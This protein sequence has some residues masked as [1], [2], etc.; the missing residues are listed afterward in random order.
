MK[1]KIILLTLLCL[2]LNTISAQTDMYAKNVN[3]PCVNKK[4]FLYI[5]VGMDSL[6]MNIL[7]EAGVEKILEEANMAFEPICISFDY[8]KID[9]MKDYSFL[10]IKDSVD[11]DL[12]TTRF[13]KERRLNVYFVENVFQPN[14]NSFSVF[15]GITLADKGVIIVPYTGK[16][17]I[18]EL[19]NTFGLHHTFSEGF[20]KET[21]DGKNCKTAGDL[22]CDTPADP[23]D[24]KEKYEK[25]LDLQR[26]NFVYLGKDPNKDY[27][28]T[29]IGNYMTHYFCAHCFFTTSQYKI[30]AETYLNSTFK[31][32]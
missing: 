29:E 5:H 30:M 12:L 20:G 7:S 11:V 1:N 21:V 16:G 26:C 8:C 22:L 28:K 10:N 32:W 2:F 13:Q 24:T 15:N 31:M 6:S 9:Y 18:H 14:Q 23:F 27:Y 25:F 4:F 3:L 17:F 19:G